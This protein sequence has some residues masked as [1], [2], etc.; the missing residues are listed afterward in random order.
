MLGTALTFLVSGGA[1]AASHGCR[2]PR[3]TSTR[4]RLP[5]GFVS[6]CSRAD[7]S[8]VL[9]NQTFSGDAQADV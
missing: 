2:Q 7:P 4:Q 3:V 1:C 5:V 6:M 8:R 9:A